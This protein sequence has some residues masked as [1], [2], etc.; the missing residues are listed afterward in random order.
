[1]VRPK[2]ILEALVTTKVNAFTMIVTTISTVALDL[3]R[4]VVIGI[5]IHLALSKTPWAN[6]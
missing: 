6:R 4:A 5:I 2:I 3:I 1:M